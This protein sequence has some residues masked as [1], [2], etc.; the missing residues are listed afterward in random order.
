MSQRTLRSL[1]SSFALVVV[2]LLVGLSA[3]GCSSGVPRYIIK[4]KVVDGDKPV[5]PDPNNSI[6]MH[7]I[8]Q[9]EEG[10][11]FDIYVTQLNAEDGTFA[12]IGNED[13]GIPAGKYRVKFRTVLVNPSAMSKLLMQKFGNEKSPILIDIVDDKTPLVIDIAPYKG[14]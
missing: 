8:Q 9:L 6:S 3:A 12:M 14:K 10:K 11:F 4:G 5:L 1:R 2:G 7:F 13:T